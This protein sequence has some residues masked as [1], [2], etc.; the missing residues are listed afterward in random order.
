MARRSFLAQMVGLPFLALGLK[1]EES[2][3]PLKIMMKSAWGRTTQPGRL[4]RS[5]TDWCWQKRGTRCKFFFSRRP[6]LCCESPWSTRFCRW[7]G[8]R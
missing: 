5:R 7:A 8:R 1:A 6:L 4:F 2:K 3:K